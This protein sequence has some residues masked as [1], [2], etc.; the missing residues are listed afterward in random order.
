MLMS[1][2]VAIIGSRNIGTDLTLEVLRDSMVLVIAAPVGIDPVSDDRARA[3]TDAR[4]GD[5]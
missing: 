5:T 2:R 1:V 4:G 3:R